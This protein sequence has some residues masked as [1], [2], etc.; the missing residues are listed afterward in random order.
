MAKGDWWSA[1]PIVGQLV[2]SFT[3]Q[4]SQRETNQAMQGM[5]Q[6]Q[7]VFQ[8]RMSNT[9]HQREVKDL[10]AAGLNPILSQHSGASSPSGG[11]AVAMQ[12]PESSYG[13]VGEAAIATALAK[14]QL[15]K[16]LSETNLNTS[17]EGLQAKQGEA[18]V[19]S[20]KAAG[21]AAIKSLNE[22][23]IIEAAIPSAKIHGELNKKM[24][25]YDAAIQRV[26]DFLGT[27]TSGK[28]I[29]QRGSAPA[30]EKKQPSTLPGKGG[31]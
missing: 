8:E 3:G 27:V 12:N 16:N 30:E 5:A 25:P 20:A 6:D 10:R 7:S 18:A 26:G 15:S 24:A 29:F 23:K 31:Y 19:A 14:S 28:K 1:V 17:T 4:Q 9:A 13:K 22:S 2:D 21:A 11:G